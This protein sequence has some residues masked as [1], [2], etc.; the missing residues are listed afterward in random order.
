MF[1]VIRHISDSQDKAIAKSSFFQLVNEHKQGYGID[2]QKTINLVFDCENLLSAKI[3][4]DIRVT[5]GV[6]KLW[7]TTSIIVVFS[8]CEISLYR[9]LTST[10]LKASMSPLWGIQK[11]FNQK[12]L[13]VTP[14]TD[15]YNE[16][17]SEIIHRIAEIF[18]T[19]RANIS[20]LERAGMLFEK[21][22]LIDDIHEKSVDLIREQYKQA[23]RLYEREIKPLT[24]FLDQHTRY[25][26]GDGIYTILANFYNA[27]DSIGDSSSASLMNAYQIQCLDLFTPIANVATTV[28]TYL[29]KTRTAIKE[30]NA[31]ERA[32]ATLRAAY[33]N[34]L[35]ADQRNR[36]IKKENLKELALRHPIHGVTRISPMRLERSQAFIHVLNNEL[37]ARQ[38]GISPNSILTEEFDEKIDYKKRKLMEYQERLDSWICEHE[39]PFHID[40]ILH[41]KKELEKEFSEFTLPDLFTVIERIVKNKDFNVTSIGEFNYIEDEHYKIKYKVR[42]ITEYAPEG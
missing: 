3:L 24:I 37:S 33:E 19:I 17:T 31:I 14:G 39:W 10:S 29:Q 4:D 25:E 11:E 26:F 34:T 38:A 22:V 13:S 35:S 1:Q 6:T 32:Y 15:D 18:G 2:D 7:F 20:K 9:P 36:F 27:F 8:L 28:N 30:H 23:N 42:Y 5:N 21:E 16:W 41:A 12:K 40:F